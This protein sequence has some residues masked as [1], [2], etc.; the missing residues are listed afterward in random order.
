MNNLLLVITVFLYSS[1]GIAEQ[2]QLNFSY[3]STYSE[4]RHVQAVIEI[5]AGTNKKIEYDYV[6][7]AFSAE[8][9]DDKER[10]VN[11]LP[12][13]GNYGFIPSTLMDENQGGDGDS[14]DVLVLSE[15]LKTGTIIEV[16]PIALLRLIDENEVDSKIIAVPVDQN[17]RIL[18][19]TSFD[20]LKSRYP[21]IQKIIE[22]WFLSY[23]GSNKIK[24]RGWEDE[25]LAN[26]V[27]IK[28][29]NNRATSE[30]MV[31]Q[32]LPNQTFLKTP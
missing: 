5:P 21:N 14:L 12:Y 1:I 13:I 30:S 23:K 25:K 9:Q 27:I 10:M 28:S 4:N 6:T 24:T 29:I 2:S 17:Q 20:E 18:L 7:N 31:K 3:I 15:H 26:I 19:A 11:F 8:L 32:S 22:L 16:I